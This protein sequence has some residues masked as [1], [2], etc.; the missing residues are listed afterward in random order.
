LADDQRPMGVFLFAGASGVG[1][2]HL[3]KELHSYLYGDE[4]DIVRIDC[5][6]YQHKHENQK[7]IGCFVLGSKVAMGDGTSM[8]IEDIQVGMNVIT[9]KGN[10]REVV[11]TYEYDTSESLVEISFAG[12]SETIKSTPDHKYFAIQSIHKPETSDRQQRR[13]WTQSAK[14]ENLDWYQAKTLQRGDWVVTPRVKADIAETVYDLADFIPKYEVRSDDEYIYRQVKEVTSIPSVSSKVYD[15]SVQDD[16]SF[17]VSGIAVSNSP[18]GYV[19]YDEGG[20]LTN[21]MKKNPN[22]V[23]L[24]DEVEKAHPDLWNT[25]LRVFDEGALTD[26]SGRTVSFKDSIVIM[27]TNLGNKEAINSMM[28]SGLGFNSSYTQD[29]RNIDTPSRSA[30]ERFATKSIQNNFKP[31]F[32]NRIDRIVIFNH[33]Q[34]EE[35]QKIA[36]L[37]LEKI[38]KKL[39]KRG[40]TLN[41][42]ESVAEHMVDQ[43]VNS[44]EGARGL[45][46]IRRDVIEDKVS[47]SLLEYSRWPRGTVVTIAWDEDFQVTTKRPTKEKTSSST[48]D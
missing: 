29:Q 25:F 23:V 9:H 28:D 47:D 36:E 44:I 22:T 5:G 40:M 12:S 20:Y 30:F 6:E 38:Q 45:A 10:I 26:G 32:L 42:S 33:L 31:E 7:L 27:T 39:R 11:D 35:M 21:Q 43:G 14:K 8:N 15:I 34:K 18:P 19:G 4:V 24:L 37:E 48:K 41:Y 2:S 16:A 13:L 3:A 17:N 1:K 46:R